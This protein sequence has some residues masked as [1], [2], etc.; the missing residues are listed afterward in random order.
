MLI[1]CL[2]Q[3]VLICLVY[4]VLR[5]WIT[6]NSLC[7]HVSVNFVDGIVSKLILFFFFLVCLLFVVIHKTLIILNDLIVWCCL[8]LPLF[9]FFVCFLHVCASWPFYVFAFFLPVYGLLSVYSVSSVTWIRHNQKYYVAFKSLIFQLSIQVSLC[10]NHYDIGVF[11]NM[12]HNTNFNFFE[13]CAI[14]KIQI[15]MA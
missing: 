7:I 14:W 6:L 5:C 9:C 13:H 10:I 3:D 15:I 11:N 12:Y 4:F 1:W 2:N 8:C